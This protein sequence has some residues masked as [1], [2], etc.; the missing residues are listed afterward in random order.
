[1]IYLDRDGTINEDFGYVSRID[2][3]RFLEGAVEA[4]G[5]LRDQGYALAIATNQS[6]ISRGM[7]S[8]SNVWQLH[9]FMRQEL[10]KSGIAIDAIAICPHGT[11]D[12]CSCRKP[13]TGLADVIQQTSDFTIDIPN[14][15]MIGDK[16]SDIGFGR[17][18]GVKTGLLTSS[19]WTT[20]ECPAADLYAESLLEAARIICQP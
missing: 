13:A 15:W 9:D 8:D 1:M 4:L 12:G 3:W 5:L 11:D 7:F 6:G 19:Y 18:I 17:A 20:D 2:Q 16:P 10:E 14:S